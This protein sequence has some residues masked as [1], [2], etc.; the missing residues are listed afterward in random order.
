MSIQYILPAMTI[1]LPAAPIED[2]AMVA[3]FGKENLKSS[4]FE[5]GKRCVGEVV[6]GRGRC[7]TTMCRTGTRSD[8]CFVFSNATLIGQFSPQISLR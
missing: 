3:E 6:R 7:D 1:R 4:W 2:D 5:V 8:V